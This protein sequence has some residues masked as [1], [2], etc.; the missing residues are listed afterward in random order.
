M[1]LFLTTLQTQTTLI[2]LFAD[3]TFSVTD[4]VALIGAHTSA[5][6]FKVSKETTGH[7]MDSTPGVWDIKFYSE[8]LGNKKMS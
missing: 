5:N 8:A 7:A 3:K 2:K 4:L 6:M 1:A